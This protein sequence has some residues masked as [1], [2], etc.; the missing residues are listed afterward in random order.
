MV[1]RFS[2]QSVQQYLFGRKKKCQHWARKRQGNRDLGVRVYINGAHNVGSN[3]FGVFFTSFGKHTSE[4]FVS[5]QFSAMRCTFS[6]RSDSLSARPYLR[7]AYAV[8]PDSIVCR[9]VQT[10]RMTSISAV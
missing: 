5:R 8:S 7:G 6:L 4:C 1:R 10:L 2:S 9:V 3:L